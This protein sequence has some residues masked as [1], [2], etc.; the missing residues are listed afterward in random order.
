MLRMRAR[1][2]R[3]VVGALKRVTNGH[4]R[5]DDIQGIGHGQFL[6]LAYRNRKIA[7]LD[8]TKGPPHLVP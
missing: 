7:K 3:V 8:S 6:V 4:L 1:E 2:A 5:H